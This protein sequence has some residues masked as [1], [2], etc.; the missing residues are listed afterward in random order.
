M[1][2]LVIEDGEGTTHVVPLIRDEIT[3]GRQD[4]NTIRLT[5]R[6]VSR[7]HARLT[8]AGTE[9]HPTIFVE[10]LDSYNG[11]RVN[12][13]RIFGKCALQPADTIQ[14]GDYFLALEQA[15]RTAV[16]SAKIVDSVPHREEDTEPT[17][18]MLEENQRAR[19]IAVSS[20]LAG[21]VYWLERRETLIG[22]T[23]TDEND[24]VINHRSISRNHV[25]VVWRE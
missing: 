17:R 1:L 10:D 24:V 18:E 7:C 22:R 13:D 6:N 23:T 15:R 8:K 9:D 2:R 11:V 25:K 14:I 3:I 5:E 4:G 16:K 21:E 19:F 20:N 12:G